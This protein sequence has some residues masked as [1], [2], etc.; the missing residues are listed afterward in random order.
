MGVGGGRT[1]E[2]C[3]LCN[4]FLTLGYWL[5]ETIPAV[6]YLMFVPLHLPNYISPTVVPVQYSIM[7][8]L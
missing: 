3:I 6:S 5:M 1:E 7:S 4:F 8:M 2:H